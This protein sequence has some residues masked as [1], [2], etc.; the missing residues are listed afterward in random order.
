[1][2]E[3]QDQMMYQMLKKV[4]DYGLISVASGNGDDT[5]ITE[6]QNASKILRMN[7]QMINTITKE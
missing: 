1:M 4:K 7:W 6:K 3:G 2:E 5:D